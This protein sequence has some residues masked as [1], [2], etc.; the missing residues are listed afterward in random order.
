MRC[1]WSGAHKVV[2]DVVNVTWRR[3]ERVRTHTMNTQ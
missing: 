2:E 3:T 1:V